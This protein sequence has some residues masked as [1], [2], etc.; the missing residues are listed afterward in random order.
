MEQTF[1]LL[2]AD[3][4]NVFIARLTDLRTTYQFNVQSFLR[5]SSVFNNT[6]SDTHNY[7][8]SAPEDIERHS[9]SLSTELFMPIKSIHKRYS[10]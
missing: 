3:E 10:I 2:N 4:E 9:K 1:R 5:L 8:Y 6:S 7:L